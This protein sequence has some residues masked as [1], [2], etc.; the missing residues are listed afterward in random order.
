MRK[1][2]NGILIFVGL[3]WGVFLIDLIL[4]WAFTD[5]GVTPRTLSGLVGVI[6]MPFLHWSFGHVVSNTIPLVVLLLLLF[7]SRTRPVMIVVLLILISGILL[8]IF[9]RSSVHVGASGLIY[10]MT[11]FLIT[12]GLMERKPVPLATAI[13]VGVLY[14]GTL[15]WGLLPSVEKDVSVE[16][17]ALGAAGGACLAWVIVR[18]KR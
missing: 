8:W 5:W 13:V 3:I 10:S 12:T 9:G 2:L 4:P 14:G 16:S 6:T 7:G 18:K 1:E 15:I 11:A 17:H